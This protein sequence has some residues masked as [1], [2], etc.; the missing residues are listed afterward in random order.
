[1]KKQNNN[2]IKSKNTVGEFEMKIKSNILKRS[3]I[4][5]LAALTIG[6]AGIATSCKIYTMPVN[7]FTL[8]AK[9]GNAATEISEEVNQPILLNFTE[10]M[11]V[12]MVNTEPSF[13]PAEKES[14]HDAD[15]I[16]TEIIK[17]SENNREKYSPSNEVKNTENSNVESANVKEKVEEQTTET[18]AENIKPLINKAEKNSALKE[19]IK[20]PDADESKIKAEAEMKE[21]AVKVEIIKPSETNFEKY[22]APE[23]KEEAVEAAN[24]QNVQEEQGIT[25]N[26]CGRLQ[27]SA[28]GLDVALYR[29]DNTLEARQKIV[30]DED[31]ACVYNWSNNNVVIADHNYQGF[32]KI[33]NCSIGTQALIWDR[34]YTCCDVIRDAVNTGNVVFSDGTLVKDYYHGCVIMYTCNN[35]GTVTVV[36]W[37]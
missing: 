22:S 28:V 30:D 6:F 5:G 18:K 4:L 29:T 25:K 11:D 13:D 12:H 33:K 21:Q 14:K 23:H 35:D 9:A 1:M 31:S 7:S 16:K 20:A 19:S 2:R 10:N 26:S 8:L 17:P 34:T 37:N 3:A 36:V 32:E 24:E 15:N 27:I